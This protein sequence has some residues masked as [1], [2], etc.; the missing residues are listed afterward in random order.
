[1][2]DEPAA[3]GGKLISL[4]PACGPLETSAGHCRFSR[5]YKQP[6]EDAQ[7]VGQSTAILRCLNQI[8][9]SFQL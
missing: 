1:M 6:F 5:A 4:S 7:K 3:R 2:I 8:W 9:R